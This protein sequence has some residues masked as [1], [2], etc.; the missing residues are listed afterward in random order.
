MGVY[1]SIITSGYDKDAFK[2]MYGK[3]EP[4]IVLGLNNI[5][6]CI[7]HDQLRLAT[8]NNSNYFIIKKRRGLF[9]QNKVQILKGITRP[10]LKIILKKY[11]DVVKIGNYYMFV[12]R[13]GEDRIIIYD[14][15]SNTKTFDYRFD[16]DFN[17]QEFEK[18]DLYIF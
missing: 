3:E 18:Y 10:D 6:S 14:S 17:F 1:H 2:K 8:H 7:S 9:K 5:H 15:V 16:L 11:G 12:K 4:A 13:P